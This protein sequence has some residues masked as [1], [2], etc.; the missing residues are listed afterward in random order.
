MLIYFSV[1]DVAR[2]A[3]TLG[4]GAGPTGLYGLM[5]RG[6]TLRKGV[7]SEKLRKEIAKWV[8]LLSNR[9]PPYALYRAMNNSRVLPADIKPGVRPLAAG[10]TTMRLISACNIAQTGRQATTTCGNTQL[11]AGTRAGIEGNLHAV[12]AI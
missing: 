1:D 2:G 10:K 7:P 4:G 11:C 12:R 8:E 9:S 5:L 6:W 3:K